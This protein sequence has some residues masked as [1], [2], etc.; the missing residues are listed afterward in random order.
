MKRGGDIASLF[1]KHEAKKL[2]TSMVY[3]SSTPAVNQ[4]QP[5]NEQEEEKVIEENHN[6]MPNSSP[7]S[8]SSA[9]QGLCYQS[10]STWSRWKTI[11]LAKFYPND[12][13][14][15]DLLNLE[16]QLDNYIDVMRQDDNCKGTN[17][18]VDLSIKLVE[19]NRDKNYE[20]ISK[21][22]IKLV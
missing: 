17:N 19:T 14:G 9:P 12:I 15:T 16:L 6:P 18:L 3:A 5:S 20:I 21:M 10:P 7:P 4:G 2:A 13:R 22:S 1:R 11:R 8:Q